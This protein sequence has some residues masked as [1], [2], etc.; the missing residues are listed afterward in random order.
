MAARA[1]SEIGGLLGESRAIVSKVSISFARTA[2][3]LPLGAIMGDP[4]IDHCPHQGHHQQGLKSLQHDPFSQKN[5]A[6]RMASAVEIPEPPQ[7][8][9]PGLVGRHSNVD[10]IPR[11]H[12]DMELEF[13]HDRVV[14]LA[15]GARIGQAHVIGPT[16]QASYGSDYGS[17]DRPYLGQFREINQEGHQGQSSFVCFVVLLAKAPI[18]RAP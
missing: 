15:D 2:S 14:H 10:V 8:V 18:C 16:A 13:L 1:A 11:A 7:R 4:Q 3:L 5:P 6:A 17:T 12:L 9:L